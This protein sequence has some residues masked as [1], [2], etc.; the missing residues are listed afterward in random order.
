M[1]QGCLDWQKISLAPPKVVV[2]ATNNYL[3]SEDTFKLWLEECCAEGPNYWTANRVLFRCFEEWCE[4]S[5]EKCGSKRRFTQTL[6]AHGFKQLR[7]DDRGSE[8][9]TI[10][11]DPAA[12]QPE[13]IW[14]GKNPR[15]DRPQDDEIFQDM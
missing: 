15:G 13:P 12:G 3:E 7:R 2:D 8:G 6:E 14:K 9:L 4:A 5:G 10:Y 1:I 11:K